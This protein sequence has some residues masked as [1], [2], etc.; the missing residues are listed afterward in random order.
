M[1]QKLNA[2]LKK[3]MATIMS[4]IASLSIFGTNTPTDPITS[5]PEANTVTAYDN[6]ETVAD[7]ILSIDPKDEIH[8]IKKYDKLAG[9]SYDI[10][11][12]K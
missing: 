6:S 7:Y 5:R 3:I 4:I 8:D 2:F 10:C 9:K 12:K 1:Q 11:R